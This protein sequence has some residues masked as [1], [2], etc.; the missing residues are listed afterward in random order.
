MLLLP[1]FYFADRVDNYPSTPTLLNGTSVSSGASANTDGSVVTALSALAFDA[2]LLVVGPGIAGASNTLVNGCLDVMRDPAGGTS[3]ASFIDDLWS[4]GH[5]SH[6]AG[7]A[8]SQQFWHFP[9]FI[10]AG[11]SLGFRLRLNIA[12][13]IA[14]TFQ[15]A[16]YGNPSHPEMWWCGQGVETIGVTAASSAGTAVTPG[17]SGSF[18]SWTSVGSTTTKR[19]GAIQMGLG[20]NDNSSLAINYHWEMGYGSNRLPGSPTFHNS[21]TTGE[22]SQHNC[23]DQL[24]RCDILPGTQMQVRGKASGTGEA[25]QVAIHGVW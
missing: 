6:V 12:G 22:Q 5:A 20:R 17:N 21:S 14:G 24:I 13:P 16:A 25:Y 2:C 23:F 9:V 4:G 19:F 8:G 3:W 15:I 11:T 10:K 18:G 7:G 1:D